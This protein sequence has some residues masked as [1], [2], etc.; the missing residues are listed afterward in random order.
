MKLKHGVL[1]AAG[2]MLGVLSTRVLIATFTAY[3]KK[4][5]LALRIR[6]IDELEVGGQYE[7]LSM[8]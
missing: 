2:W 5:S 4:R 1:I 6:S 7:P 3:L 8:N